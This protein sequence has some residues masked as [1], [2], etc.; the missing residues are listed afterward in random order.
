MEGTYSFEQ[1][2]EL[3][4]GVIRQDDRLVLVVVAVDYLKSCRC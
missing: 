1:L 2:P 3:Y 4:H